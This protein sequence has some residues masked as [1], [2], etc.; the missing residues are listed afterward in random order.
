MVSKS[1][2]HHFE[3]SALMLAPE[4]RMR[5]YFIEKH[6]SVGLIRYLVDIYGRAV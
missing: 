1:D 5:L 2:S 4:L 3:K 6:Y